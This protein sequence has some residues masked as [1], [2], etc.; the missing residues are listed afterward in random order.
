[1]RK[2]LISLIPSA[3]VLLGVLYST[4]KFFREESQLTVIADPFSLIT[5]DLDTLDF[6]SRR[7]KAPVIINFFDPSCDLCLT[8]INEI[9]KFSSQN[10]GYYVLFVSTDS[11]N[12]IENIFNKIK[13]GNFTSQQNVIF[14]R[15]D[16]ID[17]IKLF[18]DLAAPQTVIFDEGLKFKKVK[19]GLVSFAWLSKVD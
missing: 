10:Y 11:L 4:Q 7:T 18:G 15:I 6:D 19:S 14:A 8:N 16:P 1:M 5:I 2:M 12:A 17:A 3:L 13:W 9:L